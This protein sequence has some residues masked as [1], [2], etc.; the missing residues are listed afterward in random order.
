MAGDVE[1]EVLDLLH[2]TG[3]RL[4]GQRPGEEGVGMQR[5]GS[6][7]V[8]V[9]IGARLAGEPDVA[10]IVLARIIHEF[11]R[12]SRRELDSQWISLPRKYNEYS[13]RSRNPLWIQESSETP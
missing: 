7:D 10:G 9:G 5:V 1:T 3:G 6:R 8:V 13:A 11:A 12:D 4:E 2:D